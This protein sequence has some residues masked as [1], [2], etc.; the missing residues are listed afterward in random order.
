MPCLLGIDAG[1]TVTKAV[2]FGLDGAALGISSRRVALHHPAPHHV[3]R[4]PD[5][6]WDAVVATVRGVLADTG[7]DPGD[8]LAVGLTSHGD[9]LHLLDA[10][11]HAT[12]PGITS[13]D[14]RARDVVAGWDADGTSEAALPLTGQRP[15]PSAP[16]AL[17][18]WLVR[19]EPETVAASRWAV[20]AKDALQ[21]R[22]TGEVS[23]EPT[24][25]SLSFTNVATQAY[26]DDVLELYGL[27][28]QQR[29]L[30]P[31]RPSTGLA[32]AVG[33]AAARDTGLRAGTPV[34]AGAHDVDCSAV[35]SGV[36]GPGTVSVVA[37]T[38]TI[39]QVLSD[40]PST[41]PGWC[42]RNA[43]T[44]G[45]WMNMAISPTSATNMEWFTTQL[46]AA[47][48]ER[49]QA[50]GDPF[51]FVDREVEQASARPG[52]ILY[53]PFLFGSPLA[54]DASA[55]FVG[56][57][58]WHTRGDLLRAVMEGVAFV[59]RWH[60]DDLD[61][62]FASPTARLTGG[63]SRSRRWSQ[64]FADVLDRPVEVA[65]A[66]ESGALGVALLAGIA[67][68]VWP[69]PAAATAAAVRVARTHLPEPAAV[70]DLEARYRRF[71]AVVE[72]LGPV[73]AEGAA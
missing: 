19:N 2:L 67:V 44:P 38:F 66:E 69:D 53:L 1:S 3:E 61:A 45:Q 54:G 8:V 7:T 18:A 70:A 40:S 46:A 39:N 13:L 26:D 58:G 9:G 73:W 25:A 36:V 11:A 5:E 10:D 68:G 65:D 20:P 16:A 41:S 4:D 52:E 35:G 24:E 27:A 55:A 14:T 22:L 23:T 56:M 57:R 50:T 60:V 6:L 37:G 47:D 15:W 28:D 32:G 12:R 71:R 42:A 33:A 48:L 49:G 64:L 62:G 51:G 21:A 31:V 72:A 30:A 63:A 17:L 29:L 59:H 34:G 43:V